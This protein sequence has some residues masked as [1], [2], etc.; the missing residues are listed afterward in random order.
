MESGRKFKIISQL[1]EGTFGRVYKANMISGNN[2]SKVVA[3]KILHGRWQDHEE[4]VQRSRDEARVLGLLR[5]PNIVKVEDLI[6]IEQKCAVVMEFL[7]G[8]DLKTLITFANDKEILL[9]VRV[10][11]DIMLFVTRALEAAYHRPVGENNQNPLELIHRDI[12]PANIML[13]TDGEVKV[14]DFGTARATFGTREAQTQALAFGSQAYMAPE[15]MLQEEDTFYGDVFSLAVTFY[16]VLTTRRFGK[17]PL[18]PEKY[19]RDI[20]KKLSRIQLPH[21][22]DQTVVQGIIRLLD[23]MLGWEPT[24]RPDLKETR[25]RIQELAGMINDGSL[26]IYC[27]DMI[28]QIRNTQQVQPKDTDPLVGRE[29]SEDS[30]QAYPMN[31]NDNSQISPQLADDIYQTGDIDKSIRSNTFSQPSGIIQNSPITFGSRDNLKPI[32]EQEITQTELDGVAN[33]LQ[34]SSFQSMDDISNIQSESMEP[35]EKT[36]WGLNT[37]Q[38]SD[39][40][41]EVDQESSEKSDISTLQVKTPQEIQEYKRLAQQNSKPNPFV[42]TSDTNVVKS[43][44]S[45]I[46]SHTNN[47][48]GNNLADDITDPNPLP[49][50]T[51]LLSSTNKKNESNT[52]NKIIL[53]GVVGLVLLIAIIG[54]AIG[55]KSNN[56]A[57]EVDPS[58]FDL[59][60]KVSKESSVEGGKISLKTKVRSD[61]KRVLVILSKIEPDLLDSSNVLIQIGSGTTEWTGKRDLYLQEAPI[62]LYQITIGDNDY[63]IDVQKDSC[64]WIFSGNNWSEQ[65]DG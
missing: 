30:S 38:F 40:S 18:R 52:K 7:D 29:L 45:S 54:I 6:T 51:P 24:E 42:S 8:I 2:F 56:N 41:L 39:A 43:E 59:D 63:S 17:I 16:E 19:D 12:K 49:P 57:V 11:L 1:S 5:H 50:P 31:N 53:F 64:T 25:R 46:Q 14:L 47:V 36:I 37:N 55:L 60:T 4:I 3:L 21:L 27:E 26:H 62:G 34:S 13:T 22:Q 35:V 65:C 33:R 48:Q 20:K 28:V 10:T 23:D 32:R 58:E 15:R 9:P 61:K 44:I